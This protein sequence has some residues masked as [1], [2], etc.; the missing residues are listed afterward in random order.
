MSAREPRAAAWPTYEAWLAGGQRLR[1]PRLGHEVF[2]RLDGAEDA[3]RLTLLHGFPSSSHDWSMVLPALAAERR[4]LSLDFL[5][6]GDSD[7]PP[8]H[9]YSLLEQADLVQEVWE[10]VGFPADGELV[11]HDYG[12]SVAQELLA[13]GV[14]PRRVAWLNG[15]L[16]P[17]LHR[18]TEA[19]RALAGAD[20]ASLSA[21]LTPDLLAQGLRGVLSRAVD[22]RVLADL[23]AAAARRDGLRN[24]HLLLGYMAE[25][26]AHAARW[27]GALESAPAPY[28]FIWG[29][30]DPV[31]GAHMLAHV[32]ERL[33]H[34]SFTI[35]DDV[36]HYP[37]LETPEQVAPA[38]AAFLSS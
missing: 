23:A 4:V 3:P 31:S 34:A 17:D 21:S 2:V 30:S 37:Q 13:R 15:G 32:R 20:G 27:V 12:V 29:M 14:R 11:A 5:G 19:Q 7:K 35:L 24:A 1:L 28:A 18:P 22:D 8:G 36:G 33:P 16:Y 25:R 26:R 6:F 38:L 10:L 9:R